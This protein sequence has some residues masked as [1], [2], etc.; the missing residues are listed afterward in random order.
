M[1][2]KAPGTVLT[3]CLGH[4]YFSVLHLGPWT[5]R[6]YK[7]RLAGNSKISFTRCLSCLVSQSPGS[8]LWYEPLIRWAPE[9]FKGMLSTRQCLGV[10]Q[11]ASGQS[12]T[13]GNCPRLPKLELT[14]SPGFITRDSAVGDIRKLAS[15]GN[16]T[17]RVA[18]SPCFALGHL[19]CCPL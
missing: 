4:H 13:V 15:N 12:A 7:I 19:L 6:P 17:N 9:M 16:S 1:L 5:H 11:M 2:G 3:K 14:A 8:C 18:L 10:R